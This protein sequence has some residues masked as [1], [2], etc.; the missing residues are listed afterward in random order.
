V[1]QERLL[2]HGTLAAET[3]LADAR[4]CAGKPGAA[5]KERT[6]DC[7]CSGRVADAHLTQDDQVG[8]LRHFVVASSHGAEKLFLAHGRR[9]R[10]IRCRAIKLQ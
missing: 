10:E 2:N 5:A 8:I 9:F 6:R 3:I 4:A 7:R 1:T